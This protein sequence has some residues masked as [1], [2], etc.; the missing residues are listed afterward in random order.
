MCREG[1]PGTTTPEWLAARAYAGMAGHAAVPNGRRAPVE[2]RDVVGQE[3]SD[4]VGRYMD[5]K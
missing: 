2:G 1:R 3:R 4:E 5:M